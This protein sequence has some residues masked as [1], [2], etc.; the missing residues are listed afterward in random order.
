M[1][2]NKNIINNLKDK[3]D[4]NNKKHGSN[5]M[6]LIVIAICTIVFSFFYVYENCIEN[7]ITIEDLKRPDYSEVEKE[8]DMQYLYKEKNLIHLFVLSLKYIQQKKFL[9]FFQ[10]FQK[11]LKIQY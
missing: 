6:K 11:Y 9:L 3:I 1:I 8:L 4:F 2:F 5:R 7:A 10:R